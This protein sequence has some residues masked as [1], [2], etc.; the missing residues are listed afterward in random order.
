MPLHVFLFRSG[1][2]RSHRRG[3]NP[4]LHAASRLP[5][6]PRGLVLHPRRFL[7]FHPE[8]C[9]VGV[10]ASPFHVFFNRLGP[11][12]SY[13][14][15]SSLGV[16]CD[17]KKGCVLRKRTARRVKY[18]PKMIHMTFCLTPITSSTQQH[19]HSRYTYELKA[20]PS[21][22]TVYSGVTAYMLDVK[23]SHLSSLISQPTLLVE[24]YPQ[25]F[26]FW[27]GVRR[28]HVKCLE[29]FNANLVCVGTT[30]QVLRLHR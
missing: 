6:L 23:V 24:V 4:T 18:Y 22:T 30:Q 1:H 16:F 7:G 14:G 27:V 20:T 29:L 21:C 13:P 15:D 3:R 26:R 5:S 11:G 19:S 28:S 9:A 8:A 12:G 17:I 2:R 25:L 10:V